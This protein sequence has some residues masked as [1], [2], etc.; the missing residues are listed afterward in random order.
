M[1]IQQS[2]TLWI[3]VWLIRASLFLAD[4]PFFLFIHNHVKVLVGLVTKTASN[5]SLKNQMKWLVKFMNESQ[6]FDPPEQL[7]LLKPDMNFI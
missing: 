6:L 3:L 2:D 7:Q 1:F 4:S 5:K